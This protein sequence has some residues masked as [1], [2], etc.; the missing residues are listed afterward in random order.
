MARVKFEISGECQPLL[1]KKPLTG[2][3]SNAPAPLT[4][5]SASD[6][7]GENVQE[8]DDKGAQAIKEKLL[9]IESKH[10]ELEDIKVN[11]NKIIDN[12][13]ENYSMFSRMAKYW[14]SIP[15]WLKIVAGIV[16]VAPVLALGIVTHILWLLIISVV[17]LV[18][19]TAAGVFLDDHNSH[20]QHATDQL[21]TGIE[22]LANALIGLIKALTALKDQIAAEVDKLKV[23]NERLS[24]SV[25]N[26]KTEV[27][28]LREDVGDLHKITNDLGELKAVLE[29]SVKD[30]GNDVL[31]NS[32][33][34]AATQAQLS[35]VTTQYEQAQSKMQDQVVLLEAANLRYGNQAQELEKTGN[36]FRGLFDLYKTHSEL[37]EEQ[38]KVFTQN[39]NTL[40]EKAGENF[41]VAFE[42]VLDQKKL[43]GTLTEQHES[44]T[45]NI[46]LQQD[47]ITEQQLII[48][49]MEALT[50]LTPEQRQLLQTISQLNPEQVTTIYG[51]AQSLLRRDDENGMQKSIGALQ[52]GLFPASLTPPW[53]SWIESCR[54]VPGQALNKKSSV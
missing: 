17:T 32:E 26:L 31:A 1:S 49:R 36:K 6:G 54:P 10:Q 25:T 28:K 15:L 33:L 16:L 44:L 35:D 52:T 53:S 21:K 37:N 3:E 51:E 2:T 9:A 40:M 13:A 22:S 30:L 46:K 27:D 5:L 18:T 12:M 19:Y 41:H 29:K 38:H 39:L 43:M 50:R 4:N 20:I 24:E 47:L 8:V 34:L 48:A 7:L 42:M 45:A 23:E 14:G 11:L